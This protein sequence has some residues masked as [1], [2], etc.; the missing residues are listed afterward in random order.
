MMS[1]LAKRAAEEKSKS[2]ACLPTDK[3]AVC[4]SADIQSV[5]N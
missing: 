5:S 2:N 1:I 4:V 3:V